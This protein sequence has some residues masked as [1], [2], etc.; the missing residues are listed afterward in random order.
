MNAPLDPRPVT[1]EGRHARLEPLELC[2]ADELL[3]AAQHDELWLYMPIPRPR[4][5]AELVRW[6]EEALALQRKGEQLPFAVVERAGGRAIGS[7]RYLDIRR[8]H[9]GL[10]IGWTWITPAFQRSAINTECKRLLLGHAFEELGCL[11][12]Q[13]K[14]DGR[15]LRSQAAIERLGAVKE[16]VLRQH[17]LL[18]DGYVRDSVMYSITAGEWPAVKQRLEAKLSASRPSSG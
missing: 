6:I 2:H 5:R 17:M 10:E 16:G 14:T 15:N 3:A 12:V 18:H 8:A 9:R 7:M 13:L 4:T 11:R 1:L